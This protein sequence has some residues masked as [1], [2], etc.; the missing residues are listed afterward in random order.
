MWHN[1]RLGMTEARNRRAWIWLAFAA[2]TVVSVARAQASLQPVRTCTHSVLAY[3]AAS[4]Y[5]AAATPGTLQAGYGRT[6][7]SRSWQRSQSEPLLSMLPVLF[8]GLVSP[9]NEVVAGSAPCLA[10]E[11]AAPVLPFRFQRPPP[12]LLG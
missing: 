1:M 10:R 7:A 8:V 9:L 4:Q 3:L 11:C 2:I 5:E 12:T 6:S